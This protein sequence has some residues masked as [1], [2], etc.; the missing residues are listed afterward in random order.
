[1][2]QILGILNITEDSFS[3]GGRFLAEEDAR[4][5]ARKLVEDGADIIDVGPASSNPDSKPVCVREEIRRLD[6]VLPLLKE[7]GVEI[8]IDSY[9]LETQRYGLTR[10]ASYINDIKGFPYPEFY[11]ELASAEAKLIVMHSVQGG[12]ADR[13]STVQG[14][15][16]VA[17]EDFFDARLNA[18]TAAGISEQRLILDPGMGFFLS[19][20]PEASLRVLQ[21]IGRL[22]QKFNLPV[23]ISV[24]RK[25]FLRT[26]SGRQAIDSGAITLAAELYA[27]RLG[28]D[29]IRSHDVAQLR[30]GL[31]IENM[32]QIDPMRNKDD[33]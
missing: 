13:T 29:Y 19:S 10:G 15:I 11:P 31:V 4:S 33:A 16:M 3:D 18:L 24:S 32:L 6:F 5:H 14:D 9:Q 8:S 27:A 17:V 21:N 1:M 25:S 26:L 28:A 30:D 12:V 2:V 23:L 22:K 7:L 20:R